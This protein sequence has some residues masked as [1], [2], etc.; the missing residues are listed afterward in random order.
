MKSIK[1]VAEITGLSIRTLRYYDE[2]DL[3]KPTK[4]TEAGY[5]LYD[6]KALEKLQEITF[7]REM[8]IPLADIK[9]I[10]E[11]PD[12]DKEHALATQKQLLISKRNRLNGIIE[13]IDDVMKGVD[14][15][16]F[17]AFNNHEINLILDHALEPLGKDSIASIIKEYGSLE[18]FRHCFKEQMKDEK[19]Y[20]HYM[21]LYGSKEKMLEASLRNPLTKEELNGLKKENTG[22]FKQLVEARETGNE[23]LA[24]DAVKKLAAGTRQLLGIDNARYILLKMAEQYL[25]PVEDTISVDTMDKKYGA[26]ISEYVGKSIKLYYGV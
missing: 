18:S 3:L 7:F 22:V 12:Y 14:T 15:M 2:I 23:D 19:T 11:N 16:S 10:I 6:N 24:M 8:D 20:A 4:L 25:S 5:R 21:K 13:L 9:R 26:G 1:T 17:E